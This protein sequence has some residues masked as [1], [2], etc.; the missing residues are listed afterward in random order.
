MIPEDT[1]NVL[2]NLIDAKILPR[3]MST[4]K[5]VRYLNSKEYHRAKL[6]EPE[7]KEVLGR[8]RKGLRRYEFDTLKV[9]EFELKSQG[10]ID[11]S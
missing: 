9:I 6:Y 1:K 11:F 3:T 5:V 7:F 8:K 4:K 10:T 2:A